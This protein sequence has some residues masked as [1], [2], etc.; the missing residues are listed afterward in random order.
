M[1]IRARWAR[2]WKASP[3]RLGV[4]A[5]GLVA[6]ALIFGVTGVATVRRR[7]A[8][9]TEVATVSG[10]LNT[11]A[12]TVYRAL[13]DADATAAIAFLAGGTEPADLRQRYLDDIARASSALSE[14]QR[15]AD[16]EAA[17]LLDEIARELP[18]YTGLVET[19]RAYNRQGVPLGGAYLREASAHL[20]DVLLP[21]AQRVYE[22]SRSRLQ[23]GQREA[24]VFPWVL[25][26]LGLAL[27][28]ALA[29]TQVWLT[30][31]THRL[32]SPPLLV[33]TAAA[34]ISCLA[35][36]GAV[37][38]SASFVDAGRQEGSADAQLLAEARVTAL[39]VRADEALMLVARGDGGAFEQHLTEA[40]GV[41]SGLLDRAGRE[42]EDRQDI[43]EAQ[44]AAA[45]WMLQHQTVRD[46]DAEGRYEDAVRLAT[47]PEPTGQIAVF[48]RWETEIDQA[49][50]AAQGR[51][52][53]R[54]RAAR[55][56]LR[57]ADVSVILL[58]VL[59]LAGVGA[60]MARRIGE[61]R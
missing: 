42:S 59:T 33:A 53:E 44:Q 16:G 5:A 14:A 31:R 27:I 38:R 29:G 60:G 4:A 7:A 21:A 34:L 61:Y 10:P 48:A 18:V 52:D 40:F 50:G 15:D 22:V 3:G 13:S 45:N 24:S 56:T 43:T 36:T 9:V 28:A 57:W 17:P 58:T 32:L 37:S 46:L 47:G 41:S 23:D 51:F 54:A 19:A 49:L 20:R 35:V 11:R 6:L 25:L 39:Q 8:V 2:V 26:L 1:S 12:Q 55:G 30:R